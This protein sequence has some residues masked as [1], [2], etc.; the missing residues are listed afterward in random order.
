MNIH[1]ALDHLGDVSFI[2]LTPSD[3]RAPSAHQLSTHRRPFDL[4][5]LHCSD[6]FL[7]MN[8]DF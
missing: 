1:S 4:I 8:M 7:L 3:S 2:A 6:T 5:D